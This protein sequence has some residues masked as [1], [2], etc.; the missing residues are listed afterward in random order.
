VSR[1]EQSYSL[2]RGESTAA[3]GCPPPGPVRRRAGDAFPSG[4][5]TLPAD[6][7]RWHALRPHV[8]LEETHPDRANLLTRNPR[9]VSR[10]LLTRTQFRPAEIVNVLAAA[11]IQSQVH[12]WFMHRE[13]TCAHTHDV[14]VAAGNDTPR[15]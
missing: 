10:E 7:Q 9:T 12:D 15:H 14:P 8:P 6:G 4:E 2:W 3:G 11:W 13:G 5:L 1:A